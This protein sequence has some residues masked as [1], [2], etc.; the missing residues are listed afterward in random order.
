VLGEKKSSLG[1]RL[2]AMVRPEGIRLTP[3]DHPEA[4]EFY[5]SDHF[6]FAKVGVPAVSIG[7]GS[8]VV[9]K[10]AGWGQKQGDDY[11]AHR[12]HQPSDQYR[13]NMD[14]SGAVQLAEIVL[15]F[16]LHLANA[17]GVPTWSRDAEFRALRPAAVP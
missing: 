13:P 14:L 6:A 7:G 17:P 16:G 15:K 1:A 5:R 8:D 4:G 11:T 3:E 12:Y 2:A 9:G 10:P